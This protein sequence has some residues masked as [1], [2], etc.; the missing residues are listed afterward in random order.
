MSLLLSQL[1]S[2]MSKEIKAWEGFI[3]DD[4]DCGYFSDIYSFS[5]SHGNNHQGTAYISLRTINNLFKTLKDYQQT[6]VD[7]EKSC[8]KIARDVSQSHSFSFPFPFTI[9][10]IS[11][12]SSSAWHVKAVQQWNIVAS[13]RH[14]QVW[15]V[16]SKTITYHHLR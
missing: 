1:L 14:L 2:V 16:P 12:S 4:G 8:D 5:E 7:L 6:L 10:K 3:S 9:N 11:D 15:S 13:Q